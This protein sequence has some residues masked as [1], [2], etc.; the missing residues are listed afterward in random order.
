[1]ERRR[2]LPLIEPR[3]RAALALGRPAARSGYTLIEVVIAILLTA[4]IVTSV[5]S[6]SLTSKTSDVKAE[7]KLKGAVG[8]R[9]VSS[10]LRNYVT[11]D[12]GVALGPGDA[13]GWSMTVPSKG[14]EDHAWNGTTCGGARNDYALTAGDHCLTGVLGTFEAAPYNA[15]VWYRVVDRAIADPVAGCPGCSLPEV[16]ITA[17]WIDP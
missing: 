7:R 11:G 15:R 8:T 3:G 12:L 1:M 4:V 14:I 13:G 9:Q 2:R 17:T 5:F 10:L 6:V 16:T